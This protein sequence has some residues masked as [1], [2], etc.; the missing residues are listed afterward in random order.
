MYQLIPNVCFRL[1]VTL[2]KTAGVQVTKTHPHPVSTVPLPTDTRQ[3]TL[4]VTPTQPGLHQVCENV[5]ISGLVYLCISFL[6]AA[7]D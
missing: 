1:T 3:N 2:N 6:K 4:S 7:F 5:E